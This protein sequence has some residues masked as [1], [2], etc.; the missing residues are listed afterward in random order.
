MGV[1]AGMLRKDLVRRLRAPVGLVVLLIFPVAFAGMVGMAFGPRGGGG[2]QEL[3]RIRILLVDLDQGFL[4]NVIS[5]P[6]SNE[7]FSEQFEL[8]QVADEAEA[9]ARME[10]GEASGLIII[11]AGFSADL[12]DLKPVA[13]QLVKNPA[14]SILPQVVEE[15][16]RVLAVFLDT[17]VRILA[18]PLKAVGE[19]FEG[20]DADA[21][22]FPGDAVLTELTLQVASRVR[23]LTRY[24]FPPALTLETVS[25]REW[26]LAAAVTV[27][28]G[29]PLEDLRARA[30]AEGLMEP[31]GAPDAP[32]GGGLNIFAFL[33]PMVSLMSILFIGESG[34]QDLLQEAKAGTLTRQFA[35]PAGVSQVLAA[36]VLFTLLLCGAAMVILALVG[37]ALGWIP[38]AISP[39]G[40][41]VQVGAVAFAATGLATLVYGIARTERSASA[42]SSVLII[43]MSLVGGSFMP[44]Q[45]MPDL[46]ASLAP[47]TL[48]YWG[49]RGFTDLTVRGGGLTDVVVEASV[50]LAAGAATL[51]AGWW[52]LSGR[53]ARQAAT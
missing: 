22:L 44:V 34:M 50:L 40:A 24:V 25:E 36:K 49:I 39:A 33:L 38:R 3:P 20:V 17:G 10:D 11:P 45:Q 51:L 37:L 1:L 32:Q 30:T 7:E 26:P 48:N 18:E 14:E 35:S 5:G 16:A 13:L 31:A 12:L 52:R 23:P 19:T 41:L 47:Y 53:F 6:A 42:L 27:R 15:M 29:E 9:R 2:G 4:S 8:V 43:V 46:L 21:S 28:A